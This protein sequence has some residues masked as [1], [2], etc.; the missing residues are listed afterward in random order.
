MQR[1]KMLWTKMIKP[2]KLK[3]L[4][5]HPDKQQWTDSV[6]TKHSQGQLTHTYL[7]QNVTQIL[8]SEKPDDKKNPMRW[9]SSP[10][11]H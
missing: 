7:V 9:L 5:Q 3:L 1:L 10:H 11:L 8:K 4:Q 2:T 6:V